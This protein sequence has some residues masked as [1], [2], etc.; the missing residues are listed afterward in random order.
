MP[1][2]RWGKLAITV[3]SVASL[4]ILGLVI[5]RAVKIFK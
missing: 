3:Q 5:A 1:V 2:A 4:L